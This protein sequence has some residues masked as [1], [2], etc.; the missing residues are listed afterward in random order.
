MMAKRP[1]KQQIHSWT[2]YHLRGT[3]SAFI[4]IVEAPD[5]KAAIE[6]TVEEYGVPE[7][8]RNRLIAQRRG[9]H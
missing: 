6:K 8:Q 2:V 3:S 5:E 9:R 4:G 7:N 1:T